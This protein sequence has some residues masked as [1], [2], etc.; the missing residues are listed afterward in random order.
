MSAIFKASEIDER[1][2]NGEDVS[3]FFD[4]D[5][6]IVSEGAKGSK[7]NVNITLPDWVITLLDDEAER[8]ATS[9]RSVIND[10]IVD[11]ADA[12]LERRKRLSA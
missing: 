7:R 8:R 2:D 10:W 1:F 11:R 9:R 6:P 3:E 12:E 4:L 5:H